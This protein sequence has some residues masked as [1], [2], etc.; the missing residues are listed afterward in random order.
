[1][2]PSPV[3]AQIA[4]ETGA[5]YEDTLRDDDLPGDPGQAEHSYVGLMVYDVSTM[6]RDLGGDPSALDSVHFINRYD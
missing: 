2:F 1:V 3:L 5:T 4:S 6:V